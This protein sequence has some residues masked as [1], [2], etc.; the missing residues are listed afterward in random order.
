MKNAK[1]L[2]IK[3]AGH[4]ILLYLVLGL[5][6]SISFAGVLCTALILGLI[7]YFLADLGLL[8]QTNEWFTLLSDFGLAFSVIWGLSRFF[9]HNSLPG[10]AVSIAAAVVISVFEH[11]YHQYLADYVLVK[12]TP[13]RSGTA[14]LQYG[15]ESS[16]EISPEMRK[17]R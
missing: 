15:M 2:A 6:F 8:P 16:E 17:K 5:A 7:S 13:R 14:N 3:I 11:F 12:R 10:L 9:A 1:P 4:F